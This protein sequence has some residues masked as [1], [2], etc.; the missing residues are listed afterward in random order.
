MELHNF[1]LPETT[2]QTISGS[3]AE[4]RARATIKVK[5]RGES[6][7]SA[8]GVAQYARARI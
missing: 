6:D 8:R 7:A 4:I 2:Q 5:N 1:K 3:I